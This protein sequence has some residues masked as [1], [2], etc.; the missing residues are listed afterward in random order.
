MK[1]FQAGCSTRRIDGVLYARVRYIDEKGRHKEKLKKARNITDAKK[2]FRQMLAEL[3][4]AKQSNECERK[5]FAD[6]ADWYEDNHMI[7][8]Q[9]A[10]GIKIAGLRSLHTH[11]YVIK[12]FRE[13]FGDTDLKKITY[14]EINHFRLERFNTATIHKKPRTITTVNR[15][16]GVLRNMFQIALRKE[17]IGKSPFFGEKPLIMKSLEPKRERILTREE[18]AKLLEQ[19]DTA[20]RKHL[21]PVV[22][23][24]LDTGMRRGEIITLIWSDLDFD[25]RQINIKAFNTKTERARTI[26]MTE[27][28]FQHLMALY[29]ASTKKPDERVF[30]IQRDVKKGWHKACEEAK[31]EGLRFHDLRHTFATR[32]I[33]AGVPAEFVSKLLGHTNIETTSRYVNVHLQVAKLAA[34]ALETQAQ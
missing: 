25:N 1:L 5:T 8:A 14:D 32:L 9:Y 17:W 12:V 28:V 29:E 19:C 26:V 7:P 30:G 22:I 31:I 23:T 21:R 3:E 24:A 4:E 27:R 6:L 11:K 15:E 16:L 34:S 2:L 18:E 13:H 10:N 33:Q 20:R